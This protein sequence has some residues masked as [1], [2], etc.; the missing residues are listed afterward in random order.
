L[1]GVCGSAVNPP[2]GE[3]PALN[4]EEGEGGA[5]GKEGGALTRP[6]Q[7]LRKRVVGM[8][9]K[10]GLQDGGEKLLRASDEDTVRRWLRWQ[11][12]GRQKQLVQA[13]WQGL[14]DEYGLD[15]EEAGRKLATKAEP[16]PEAPPEPVR[17]PAPEAKPPPRPASPSPSRPPLAF[18]AGSGLRTVRAAIRE[19]EL[20]A[21]PHRPYVCSEA[22]MQAS[23]ARLRRMYLA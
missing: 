14:V 2:P 17:P 20:R 12:E 21:A 4:L 16:E 18:V 6:R 19:P 10:L 3:P 5:F 9:N 8:A 23:A 7:R 22:E 15:A 11:R 1:E 13:L